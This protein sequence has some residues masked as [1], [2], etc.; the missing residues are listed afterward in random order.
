MPVF[1]DELTTTAP[2]LAVWK[3]LYDPLRFSEWWAGIAGVT[4]GDA[5]GGDADITLWP[6]GYPDFPLPQRVNRSS[7][8]QRVV[9]SC[10]VSDLVFEWRLE[11]DVAGTRISVH[12]EIPETEAAREATQKQIVADS[13]RRLASVAESVKDAPQRPG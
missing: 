8:E 12:V 5:R 11:P 13:L 9:V 4:S 3:V 1:D 10:T 2:P 6:D 7:D